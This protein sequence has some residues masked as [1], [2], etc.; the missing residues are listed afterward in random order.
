MKNERQLNLIIKSLSKDEDKF[1][2]ELA[3]IRKMID[4][5]IDSLQ[6]IKTYHD[7]CHK[8][9][10]LIMTKQIPLLVKNF[11]SFGKRIMDIIRQ[12]EAE[13][14]R[15]DKIKQG[16]ISKVSQLDQKIKFIKKAIERVTL[17]KRLTLEKREQSAIDDLAANKL[18]REEYE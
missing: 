13:I 16:L 18:I 2:L 6:R 11:S 17:D 1:L 15:L 12:E 7:D 4:A 8:N 10:S 9:D 14:A 3:K 5:K